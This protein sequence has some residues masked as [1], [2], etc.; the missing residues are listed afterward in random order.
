MTLRLASATW[1]APSS[2][3]HYHCWLSTPLAMR[4]RADDCMA[5]LERAI[6]I[7]PMSAII[8]TLAGF[9]MQFADPERGTRHMRNGF[10]MQPDNPRTGMY[11]G[12]GLGEFQDRFEE[13][14]EPL[15]HSASMGYPISVAI[16]ASYHARLG[17]LEAS[18]RA[19]RQLDRIAAGHYVSPFLLAIV[20]AGHG[21]TEETLAALDACVATGD[22]IG[23]M[24]LFQGTFGF[25]LDHPR[26]AALFQ[27]A[28]GHLGK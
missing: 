15:E 22:G 2:S 26:T 1:S 14:L 21:R 20:A 18:A 12:M 11:L 3:A 24:R 9:N 27:Q 17:N 19:E 13:A 25:V 5:H 6:E 16:L 10:E 4:G 7:E 28:G 23:L 8:Q